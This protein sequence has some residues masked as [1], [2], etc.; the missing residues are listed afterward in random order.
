MINLLSTI[1][2]C[3][4]VIFGVL[5]N[6]NSSYESTTSL[7]DFQTISVM[8]PMTGSGTGSGCPPNYT[9]DDQLGGIQVVDSHFETPGLISSDQ[10]IEGNISVEYDSG[11]SIELLP[12]F[13]VKANVEFHAYIDGC[14]PD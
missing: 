3:L 14:V 13:E 9:G 8:Q 4:S 10:V 2:L 6:S 1:T 7:S 11:T 5:I 12:G